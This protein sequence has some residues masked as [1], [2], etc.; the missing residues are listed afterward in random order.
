[1]TDRELYQKF[2]SHNGFQGYY[3]LVFSHVTEEVT[4]LR[5]TI[6]FA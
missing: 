1:M 5:V 4:E 2:S 6:Y 3:S